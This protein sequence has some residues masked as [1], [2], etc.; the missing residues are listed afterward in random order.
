MDGRSSWWRLPAVILASG[1]IACQ[2]RPRAGRR[3]GL[4]G[5]DNPTALAVGAL[6]NARGLM[7][8][9]ILNI[10]A[11]A[12]LSARRCSRCSLSWRW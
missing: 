6:M 9:I 12:G 3:R 1:S 10:G 5:Q 4:T 8:L 2:G 7:E 11:N